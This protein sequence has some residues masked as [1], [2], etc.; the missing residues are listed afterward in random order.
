MRRLERA[1]ERLV[2]ALVLAESG[3]G[4]GLTDPCADGGDEEPYCYGVRDDHW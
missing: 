4:A 2:S 1:L 3:S